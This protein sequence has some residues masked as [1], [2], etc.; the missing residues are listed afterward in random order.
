MDIPG[1]AQT[2]KKMKGPTVHIPG[3]G[4]SEAD[5]AGIL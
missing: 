4:T 2:A 5:M 1:Y 3:K